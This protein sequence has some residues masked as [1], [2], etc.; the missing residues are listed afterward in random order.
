MVCACVDDDEVVSEVSGESNSGK[1]LQ[2][3]PALIWLVDA[4]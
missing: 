4:L 2:I 1:V 3:K